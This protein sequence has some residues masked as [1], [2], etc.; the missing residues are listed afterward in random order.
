MI[1][2][3]IYIAVVFAAGFGVGRVKNKAKLAAAQA[4][5]DAVKSAA[6]KAVIAIKSKI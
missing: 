3:I 1:L 6:T 5:L 4:E 2:H